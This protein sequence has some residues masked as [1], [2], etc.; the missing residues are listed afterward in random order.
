MQAFYGEKDFIGD[1][2]YPAQNTTLQDLFGTLDLLKQY[3][4]N[5]VKESKAS[6][7]EE[8]KEVAR[9][10]GSVKKK[11]KIKPKIRK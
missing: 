6:K 1:T 4:A 7:D 5:A 9:Y 3:Q 2:F 8:E 10:G 11:I